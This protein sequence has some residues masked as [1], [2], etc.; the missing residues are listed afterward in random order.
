MAAGNTYVSI[1]T[2]S[3]TSTQGAITFSSI[4]SIYT[5][6]VIVGSVL[7]NGSTSVSLQFNGDTTTN[8]SYI[9]LD[10]SGSSVSS[11]KQINTS[12][13]Q[14]AGWSR[15][16]DSATTPSVMVANIM[17]YSNTTAYKT[18]LVNSMAL[19][20]PGNCVD[21]FVG[22]WRSTA[23]INS[24]LINSGFLAGTVYSLYGIAAA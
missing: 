11:P 21:A 22:T 12:G 17:N 14:F 4:P 1:A 2:Y 10:G 9:P 23:A 8:Y 3:A 18:A 19:G 5:D 7:G 24:I 6:L 13:I 20:T 15:N 16:L